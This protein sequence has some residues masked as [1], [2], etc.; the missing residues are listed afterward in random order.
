M[1][2]TCFRLIQK[3]SHSA[4]SHTHRSGELGNESQK[5]GK[6]T[7]ITRSYFGSS[8]AFRLFRSFTAT[9]KSYLWYLVVF[10]HLSRQ[11][12][13]CSTS[14][15][16][17]IWRHRLLPPKKSMVQ[18]E[19]GYP[20]SRVHEHKRHSSWCR[21]MQVCRSPRLW[22]SP[23]KCPGQEAE[24]GLATQ[25][26]THSLHPSEY[27]SACHCMCTSLVR[28]QFRGYTVG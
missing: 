15:F 19:S 20:F 10:R 18:Y 25:C 24:E 26:G 12:H 13:S 7:T 2:V 17:A 21:D 22:T 9:V 5:P 4:K 3:R 28:Q 1:V 8:A 11:K 6:S 16:S 27:Q 14:F 23:Q